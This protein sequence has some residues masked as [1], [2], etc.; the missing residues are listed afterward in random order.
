MLQGT[1]KQENLQFIESSKHTDIISAFKALNVKGA[2]FT[3]GTYAFAAE[4]IVPTTL[5]GFKRV[6][7]TYA[8]LP[9]VIAINSDESMN[10]LGKQDFEPQE[11]RAAK[12]AEPLAQL[13]P[14][15]QVLVIYYDEKTPCKL[16]SFLE[17][18]NLTRTLHKWGYGTSSEAPKIE[19]AECFEIVYGFPLPNDI[20]PVCYLD[21]DIAEKPQNIVVDDLRDRLISKS[22]LLFDVPEELQK[23][24]VEK[25]DSSKLKL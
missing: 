9:L 25:S 8:H 17:K 3:N 6:T 10:K 7:K 23:Y 2:H 1:E 18:N 13:F 11:V 19:G 16:Y 5:A 15:N 4:L 24:S 12:V 22:G 20:K 14:K 21:T